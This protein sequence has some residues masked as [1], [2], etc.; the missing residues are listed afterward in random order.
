MIKSAKKTS[1]SYKTSIDML[2]YEC[3]KYAVLTAEEEVELCRDMRKGNLV[4]DKRIEDTLI[5]ANTRYAQKLAK[6]YIDVVKRMHGSISYD[7]VVSASLEGLCKAAKKF[8][9]T[10]GNKFIT[11]AAWYSRKCI[12][13]LFQGFKFKV[14]KNEKGENLFASESSIDKHFGDG[15]DAGCLLDLI[16]NQDVEDPFNSLARENENDFLRYLID[17]LD[18]RESYIIKRHFG[19][20]VYD[21]DDEKVTLELIGDEINLTRERVR[22]IE[23][24][25]IEKLRYMYNN[26]MQAAYAA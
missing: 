11:Y 20:L 12:L 6:N 2:Q 3:G 21:D 7:D 17:K 14:G 10:H 4:V 15:E 8:M 23:K 9:P 22:Q 16:E 13:R 5:M 19:Y 1:K 25:G 18:D 24:V 26:E